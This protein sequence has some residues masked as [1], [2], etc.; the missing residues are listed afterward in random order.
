MEENKKKKIKKLIG[1][2]L[3]IAV[4]VGLVIGTPKA[5][6]YALDT[7]YPMAAITSGSMWPVLKQGDMVFIKGIKG[8]E[9]LRIGDVIVYKNPIGFTIH[10]IIE[11]REDTLTT[12]GDANNV[13]DSPIGYEE[14]IGKAVS[15]DHN[16]LRIP[17]LGM[18][19]ILL[20]KNKS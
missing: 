5:L 9:D 17:Y 13:S 7:P 15:T 20:N 8:K 4:L 14:I 16:P 12:K 3:Y 2:I 1:W 10:R 11:M 18:I 6:S 19:S